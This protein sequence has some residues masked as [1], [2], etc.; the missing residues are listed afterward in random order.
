MRFRDESG[1]SNG[2]RRIGMKLVNADHDG[3]RV[4]SRS[5]QRDDLRFEKNKAEPAIRCDLFDCEQAPGVHTTLTT[6]L[7]V[8]P[9]V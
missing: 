1:L 6:M 4:R 7:S 8:T 9:S 2:L 5:G 3:N